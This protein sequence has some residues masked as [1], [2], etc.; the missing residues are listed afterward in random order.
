[1]SHWAI[2]LGAGA[3]T[4]GTRLTGLM[5]GRRA[6]PDLLSRFLA[7][8][9]LAVFASLITPDLGVG[10]AELFPRLIGIVAAGAIVLRVRQLWA[11]LATGM[12]VYWVARAVLGL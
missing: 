9:P 3:V 11:G 10:T 4:Y 8:V 12:A 5:L 1:M 6:I 7:Y 2:I